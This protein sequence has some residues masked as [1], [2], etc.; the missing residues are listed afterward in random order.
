MCV[1][2]FTCDTLNRSLRSVVSKKFSFESVE[3]SRNLSLRLVLINW[4]WKIF[5]S[6]QPAV[7]S[8][9]TCTGLV[10]PSRW[11]LAM[12]CRSTAGFQSLSNKTNRDAPTRFKPMPPDLA[13][14]RNTKLMSQEALLKSETILSRR[15]AGVAPSSRVNGSSNTFI[16]FSSTSSVWVKFDTTT[17][18]SCLSL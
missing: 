11:I 7:S 5:S 3:S 13:L 1:F 17:T 8:R 12:A 14:R 16:S 9:Y 4:R 10:W 15:L 2:E 18:F 6:M